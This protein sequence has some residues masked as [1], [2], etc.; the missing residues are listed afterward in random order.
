MA[1]PQPPPSSNHEIP[2]AEMLALAVEGAED[3]FWYW[4]LKTGR[5][6]F[7]DRWYIELGYRP[8]EI[9]PNITSWRAM[10]HPADRPRVNEQVRR[11]LKKEITRYDID[12]RCKTKA[13]TYKWF[14]S[15]GQARWGADGEPLCIAGAISDISRRR[16]AEEKVRLLA[17]YDAVTHLPNRVELEQ[18]A[19]RAIE[20]AVA[21]QSRLAMMYIDIDRF[22]HINDSLGHMV[23]DDLLRAIGMRFRDVVQTQGTVALQGGDEF[24]VLLEGL[25]DAAGADRIARALLDALH[26]P[27]VS[28]PHRIHV[29]A[30][31]GISLF[32]D[33]ARDVH[34]LLR[35]ADTAMFAAKDEGRHRIRFYNEKMSV[36]AARRLALEQHLR[37]ALG[38]GELSL[39]YQPLV[40]LAD[41][42]VVGAEALLR[43]R[44]PALGPVNTNAVH[45]RSARS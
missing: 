41:E 29:S 14:R 27:C 42:R 28:G 21:R 45:L 20:L 40:N 13:G 35:H 4:D 39:H 36:A 3:G 32:P 38:N 19:R 7:S 11:Y 16:A 24:I 9:A 17:Y 31:I 22:K 25:T 37:L 5:G 26:E 12:F 2:E 44:H 10:I 43:W 30:S 23:G 6:W 18:R 34:E 33:D 1:V 15:R 8:G